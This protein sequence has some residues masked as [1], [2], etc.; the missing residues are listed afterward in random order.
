MHFGMNSAI[1]R[2]DAA[3][4]ALMHFPPNIFRFSVG[5]SPE[6]VTMSEKTSPNLILSMVTAA[7]SV[8]VIVLTVMFLNAKAEV[9]EQRSQAAQAKND[10]SRTKL[11]TAEQ[12]IEV[13]KIVTSLQDKDKKESERKLCGAILRHV[14]S[15]KQMWALDYRKKDND[16]PMQ[17]D[18]VGPD[19]YLILWQQC[20]SGGVIE[21]RSVKDDPY[22]TAHGSLA[23]VLYH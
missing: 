23:N 9:S 17:S 7:L 3:F 2:F 22:C 15:A 12:I 4:V 13:K 6:N 10:L 21:I 16:I 11:E 18:L 19:K 8:A 1:G 5:G 14:D 20:P